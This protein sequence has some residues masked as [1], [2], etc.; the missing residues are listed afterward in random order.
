MAAETPGRPLSAYDTTAIDTP[1]ARATS[2]MVG[3]RAA[4]AG[5]DP[6]TTGTGDVTGGT[7]G[8]EA[9]LPLSCAGVTTIA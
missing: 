7:G 9:P 3:R 2:V 4:T 5:C 8:E 6:V 1:A